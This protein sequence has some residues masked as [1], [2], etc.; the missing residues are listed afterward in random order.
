MKVKANA[1]SE[2]NK[3]PIKELGRVVKE[4]EIFEILDSRVDALVNGKNFFK[5]AFAEIVKEKKE[6]AKPEAEM[7]EPSKKQ[8]IKEQPKERPVEKPKPEAIKPKKKAKK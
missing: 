2:L 8:N 5:M 7:E 1:N 3:I 6:E 4:G